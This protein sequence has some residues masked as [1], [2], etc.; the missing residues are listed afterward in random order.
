M[1]RSGYN[2][3]RPGRWVGGV[4]IFSQASE[5]EES[6]VRQNRRSCKKTA[7]HC[8][9]CVPEIIRTSRDESVDGLIC[10]V[11]IR[12]IIHFGSNR[13]LIY[14]RPSEF[15]RRARIKSPTLD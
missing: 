15:A 2:S 6:D 11:L 5:P 1:P 7:W 10:I 12:F 14:Q 4:I 3:P 13:T 8:M 9:C